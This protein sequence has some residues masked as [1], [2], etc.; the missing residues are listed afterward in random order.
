METAGLPNESLIQLRVLRAIS[1]L[2]RYNLPLPGWKRRFAK[3]IRRYRPCWQSFDTLLRSQVRA[4]AEGLGATQ[5]VATD[6]HANS[7]FDPEAASA[8]VAR[9]KGLLED[10]DGD[11]EEAFTEL[12][13]ALAGQVEK[14]RLSALGDAIRDFEFESALVKLAEIA[15][16]HS[17]SGGKATR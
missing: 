12:Q 2:R 4:I 3:M 9:L 5:L 17:L 8:A 10:S 1:E 6:V 13:D 7:K 14:T 11:A 16:E 15:H